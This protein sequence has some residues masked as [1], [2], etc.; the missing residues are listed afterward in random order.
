MPAHPTQVHFT[1]VPHAVPAMAS[2][3]TKLSFA[4]MLLSAWALVASA[5]VRRGPPETLCTFLPARQMAMPGLFLPL[6]THQ[7]CLVA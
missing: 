7:K 4:L 2:Q 6:H 3:A 5:Q 1:A